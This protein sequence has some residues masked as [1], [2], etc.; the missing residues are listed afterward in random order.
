MA[1]VNMALSPDESKQESSCLLGSED[2]DRGPK[3]PY[4]LTIQLD[5]TV[6]KKLGITELPSVGQPM[7][8]MAVAEVCST[9]QYENQG[10]SEK[11]VSLQI[12]QLG[13]EQSNQDMASALYGA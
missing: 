1:L 9:S 13:I 2:T 7:R 6:L 11:C 3:Y 5:E 8:L 12:T 4:G 10:G